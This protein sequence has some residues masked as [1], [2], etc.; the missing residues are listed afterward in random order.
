MINYLLDEKENPGGFSGFSFFFLWGGWDVFLQKQEL[1]TE[2]GGRNIVSR[3]IG[4]LFIE[5]VII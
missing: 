1:G 2:A 5:K 4:I 3:L